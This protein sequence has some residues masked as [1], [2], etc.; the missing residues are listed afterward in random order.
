MA[1]AEKKF[2]NR[3]ILENSPYLLQ[4]AHNPVDWYPWGE[5]AFA[6]A[7]REAKPI[8]LSSGYSSCHWCHVMERESFE[9]E[10]IAAILNRDFVPVKLDREQRP[11]VDAVYM[12]A[13]QLLTGH[14]GWPLSAF[15]TPDGRPFF[16]GTYFPPQAFKRLLQQVA[17]AWRSR[18]AEIEAQAERLKQA[19]LELESTHPGEIGPE[20]VEAAIAE[21]LAPFD[22]RHGGFGAA[23]KFPNEPWLALLIDELWR[24]DDPKV[25][26]VVRKTLDAMARGGLCDQIGD[27]FH[28]YCVDAAFQI[29]H[30]EKMLYNQAQLGRLYARA[31][32][33]TKDALFAYAARCTFDFVLRELTAPEGGF[34]AAIDAD[35]EGEEGKFYLW[36]PEEIRAALPKDDAELAIE[37]FGVSASGNFEGKN[38][39]H[40]P[41]PLAEIAQAK[42]MTEEELLACLDRIR[43]RLYQVRR[44]RVPPLRDDKIVT[45]WNGMMIAAL[46]EAAR[47][48]HEPK[49]LLAARR[50][51]EFLSRHHLQGERLLRASRNGRPAGEGLQEDYAFLAEGFLALYDVSADPV[52]LQE[53]EALTAAMLAQFWDEAR[54]ACFMNRA[55]ERLAVRPKDLF[56][57]AYPSGNAA[58]ARVLAR[59][60]RRTGK[61]AYERYFK[62][63][64][65]ALGAWVRQHPSGFAYL[66]LAWRESQA[67]EAGPVQWAAGGQVRL[68][69]LW[70][71]REG[72]VW[73]RIADGWH[74]NGPEATED[75][76]PTRLS[77]DWPACGWRLGP[78]AYP[79]PQ[80]VRIFDSRRPWRGYL[81]RVE[82]RFR[83]E[84]AGRGPVPLKLQLQ[85]CGERSCLAPET[86]RFK[87]PG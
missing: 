35:S 1:R 75:L 43:Q 23:P 22:P 13:V 78:I 57:G 27:G 2:T 61:L 74:L 25:L 42:G 14:G 31:A 72:V 26:E 6:K 84:T 50:A 19:L 8:F 63:L 83:I 49:Y 53:A 44:R 40:L 64:A 81:G 77:L 65:A 18:R 30:F 20:T 34:Y 12:H 37:L 7:R 73:L 82:L 85:A 66:L 71:G 17:E 60:A 21:I 87:V 36:T 55:D 24:G 16:G 39:L 10:E 52:W 33:L 15:L 76:I 48:F 41:R 62:P 3:L 56:D 54:G 51:A 69:G 29:P 45:A 58:A 79:P 4:H 9:D 70:Q 47:L 59:L 86:V 80:S 28:R 68:S 11:D 38:V 67:G 32:A 46:A 5:E